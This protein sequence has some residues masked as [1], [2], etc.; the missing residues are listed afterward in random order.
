MAFLKS[1]KRRISLSWAGKTLSIALA[2]G[3]LYGAETS[4]AYS[5]ET[6]AT[7]QGQANNKNIQNA[8]SGNAIAVPSHQQLQETPA[9]PKITI[10]TILN[11][12]DIDLYQE[13]FALQKDGKW[14]AADKLIR[15][16]NDDVLMSYVL[17]QRYMHPTKYRSKY[18]ELRDWMRYY[19]DH[20]DA[21]RVYRLAKRRQGRARGPKRPV[22]QYFKYDP[23]EEIRIVDDLPKPPTP[24]RSRA[25]NREVATFKARLRREISRG[26]PERA[27][28]RFWAF[29]RLD[30]LSDVEY[31]VALGQLAKSYYFEGA[32]EKAYSLANLGSERSREFFSEGNWYA[33]LAAWRMGNYALSAK[34]FSY[35]A[36]N[37]HSGDWTGSA[38]A[39]WAAR[40]NTMIGQPEKSVEYLHQAAKEKHTF[41]GIIAARQLGLNLTYDWSL[42]DISQEG[43]EKLMSYPAIE[44]AMALREVG[45]LSDAD[46]EFRLFWGREGRRHQT[47]LIALAAH[48]NL[49]SAQLI[50]SKNMAKYNIELPDSVKYPLPDWQPRYDGF[51]VDRALMFGW[52]HQE[53]NFMTRA[54]SGAGA[55]GLMQVTPSTA[56]F[57]MNDRSLRG[58]RKND[59]LI[60]DLNMQISQKYMKHLL[61]GDPSGANFLWFAAA[62]NAGPGNLVKWERK[63]RHGGDPFLFI[64]SL[65]AWETRNHIERVFANM[66]IY[67]NR[68]GQQAP[69]LDALASGAWPIYESIDHEYGFLTTGNAA[70]STEE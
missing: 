62:Y 32:D 18:T 38:G 68:L 14:Q 13:V 50:L 67:R 47:D 17:H 22:S 69:S 43:L 29:A 19:A 27:E 7:S 35:V 15:Q 65:I 64:E 51:Q 34:H 60:P 30:L 61:D 55:Y 53:S 31:D 66:W 37:P 23:P 36:A 8:H 54:H 49:P 21:R 42:P 2:A 39:F 28:K 58:S 59:L 52:M 57:I 4:P 9:T 26:R 41:Y 12:R 1:R 33:G 44:R 25:E 40:A 48:L 63:S 20:P 16:I 70:L 10:P 56:S 24:R 6:T 11:Q 45:R 5:A 3:F 46:K